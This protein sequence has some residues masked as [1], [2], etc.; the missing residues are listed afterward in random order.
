MDALH[1]CCAGVDVHKGSVFACVRR[2]LLDGE[3]VCEVRC[4]G[5]MTADLLALR[6]WFLAA[7]VAAVALEAAGDCWKPVFE[8]LEGHVRVVLVG[9]VPVKPTSGRRT[10]IGDCARTARLLQHGLAS[11]Q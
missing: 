1:R 7:G 4:F 6:D 8:I 3:V 2:L 11:E 10:D 9:P 5:T